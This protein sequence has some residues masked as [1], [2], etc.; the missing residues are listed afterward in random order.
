M[1]LMHVMP[2]AIPSLGTEF[3][4][5]SP[6]RVPRQTNKDENKRRNPKRIFFPFSFCLFPPSPLST[7]R[8][9]LAACLL[10]VH[11]TSNTGK[12]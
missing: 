8:P 5:P 1:L 3:K 12:G 9:L 6:T 7:P 11:D 2:V 10:A 4:S